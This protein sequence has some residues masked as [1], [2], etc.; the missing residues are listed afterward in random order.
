VLSGNLNVTGLASA[1][2]AMMQFGA[3]DGPSAR[4][5]FISNVTVGTLYFSLAAKVTSL[6]ALSTNGGYVAAFNNTRGPQTNTPTVLGTKIIVRATNGGFNIGTAKNTT[7]T[8]EFV[9]SPGI[10]KT[11]EVIFFVGSYTFN[12]SSSSDDVS[13]LWINPSA[14]TFGLAESTPTLTA[15]S[16]ADMTAN[17]IASFVFL[18]RGLGNTN[19][20]DAMLVDELRIGPTWGSVTP[21]GNVP[22]ILSAAKIG[23]QVVLFWPTNAPGFILEKTSALGGTNTWSQ[24]TGTVS[25]VGAQFTQTNSI[26]GTLFYRLRK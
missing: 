14:S 18:Q 25:T 16:G 9:W 21:P 19:Q 24:A 2:G 15:T 8:A 13:K 12:A 23:N 1:S 10:F 5:N 11:N 4:F 3:V 20:P 17:Q 6:G 22:P 7:N 26:A